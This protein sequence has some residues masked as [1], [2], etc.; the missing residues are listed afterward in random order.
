MIAYGS[1]RVKQFHCDG[2]GECNRFRDTYSVEYDA[3]GNKYFKKTGSVDLY[4]KIQSFKESCLLDNI[5]KR[6][7]SD[8]SVL[9]RTVGAYADLTELPQNMYD[10]KKVLDDAQKIFEG[11]DDDRKKEYNN[12]FRTFLTGFKHSN[13]LAKFLAS[14]KAKAQQAAKVAEPAPAPAPAPAHSD[15]GGVQ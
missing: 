12:D 2:L 8:P 15:N 4:E 10:A 6:S 7:V 11:F 14:E 1:L 13:G 5:L 3:A 9:Q